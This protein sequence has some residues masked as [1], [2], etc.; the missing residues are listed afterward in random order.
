MNVTS[1]EVSTQTNEIYHTNLEEKAWA[2]SMQA[3]WHCLQLLLHHKHTVED[4]A[5]IDGA[6]WKA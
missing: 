1:I 6:D 5:C 3:I 2:K 4:S